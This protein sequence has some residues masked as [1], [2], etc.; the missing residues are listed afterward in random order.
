MKYTF[1][2]YDIVINPEMI[3]KHFK[4]VLLVAPDVF[5]N[6]LLTDFK[7]IKHITALSS[8]FPSLNELK[9]DMVIFDYDYTGEG[10][11]KIIRRIKINNFY[12][13]LKICCYKSAHDE[14]TDSLL[15][16]LGVDYVIYEEDLVRPEKNKT[17][18]TNL[19]AIFDTSIFK[20]V[21]NVSH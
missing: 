8:I 12:N 13:K 21:A 17:L 10:I 20:W 7:N 11:E 16:A 4:K 15:K 14:K 2:I 5:P 6:Q 1:Y 19:G 18:L 9:P 3:R